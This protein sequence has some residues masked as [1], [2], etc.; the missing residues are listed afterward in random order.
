MPP[1]WSKY[2]FQLVL[3]ATLLEPLLLH[4]SHLGVPTTPRAQGQH[5]SDIWDLCHAW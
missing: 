5:W 4:T 3:L 2:R 1:N